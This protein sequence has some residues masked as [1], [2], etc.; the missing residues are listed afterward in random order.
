MKN[1]GV[2]IALL[3]GAVEI[4]AMV[5]LFLVMDD[6]LTKILEEKAIKDMNVIAQDRAEL[7][8]AYIDSCCDLLDGYSKSAEIRGVLEHP[9]DEAALAASREFTLRYADGHDNI[10]GL[11][12]AKWDTWVLAHINPDSMDK[13]FREADSAKE[14]EDR[15]RAMGCSFCTG[16]VLAPVTRNMVIP[17]YAPVYNAEG[18]AI[19]FAG[20]A[21][22]PEGLASR[23]ES[24]AGDT[25]ESMGYSIFNAANNIFIFD[26]DTSLVG[27]ECSDSEILDIMSSFREAEGRERFATLRRKGEI[28]SFYYMP[29]RDWV[30]AVTDAGADSLGVVDKVRVN[31]IVI[32]VCVTVVMMALCIWSLHRMI[33]PLHAIHRQILRLNSGDY[34]RGHGIEKYCHRDDEFGT[35]ANA[36]KEL[37]ISLENQTELFHEIMEVQM[38]GMVV[39]K[40][41]NSRVLMI[42]QT[43]LKLYGIPEEEKDDITIEGIRARFTDEEL[44]NIDEQLSKVTDFSEEVV[45]ESPVTY[46]DGKKAWLLTHVKTLTLSNSERVTI[47]SLMDITERK[48]M[49][50]DLQMQAETD[51]LT[52][53][54]NRRSGEYRIGQLLERGEGG[55]FCLFD[56]NK[57]KLINDGYGHAAGDEVLVALAKAMSA[58]FR[59]S[60][61]L[62]R[63]GGDEFVVYAPSVP[64]RS[65][66]EKLINRLMENVDKIAPESLKGHKVSISL[67]AVMTEGSED[68]ARLYSRADSLMYGC[69]AK[70]GN[71]YEFYEG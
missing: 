61:I 6:N 22:Y 18:E 31:I 68:F 57:F 9:E 50:Q 71:A 62:V 34:S 20:A 49:E 58:T 23:L 28:I 35:I 14:L 70:G 40:E 54:S 65:V 45:F 33:E 43:A 46:S 8:E 48:H 36:V 13:T 3:L 63:L 44:A 21:F 11:Y 37:H 15:I 10:E 53:I 42:N 2:K 51:A 41:T 59:S 26:H 38:T 64:D 67:G 24:A 16:V 56:A 4:I 69:K 55:L 27:T 47:Y 32:L 19:G 7:A 17:V 66:A 1:I 30:F 25:D 5:V 12:V 39:A 60:D 52:G 29:E